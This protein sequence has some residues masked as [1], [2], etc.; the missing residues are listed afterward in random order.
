MIVFLDDDKT[1]QIYIR[2]KVLCI[3]YYIN[4]H[5]VFRDEKAPSNYAVKTITK[6]N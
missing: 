3:S 5:I 1:N 2:L 6:C 4:I